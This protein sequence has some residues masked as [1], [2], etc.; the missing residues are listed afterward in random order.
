MALNFYLKP[1]IILGR[2]DVQ[3]CL[4]KMALFVTPYLDI[5]I[6]IIV[7]SISELSL[8]PYISMKES[9]PPSEEI[10]WA[11]DI[12]HIYV[13]KDSGV[14]ISDYS[15]TD[16]ED[17]DTDLFSGGISGISS[18]LQEMIDSEQRIKVI[19]HED[20]KLLFEHSKQFSIVLVAKKD[21]NIYHVKLKRLADEIQS[22]FWETISTWNGDLEIFNPLKTMIR[23]HFVED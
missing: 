21:L 8:I 13:I 3:V 23:N 4:K 10:E 12:L 11:K 15:F 14:M 17:V 16:E 7:I 19:D 1:C 2:S 9:L 5:M 6:I 18:I 22:I 20:K